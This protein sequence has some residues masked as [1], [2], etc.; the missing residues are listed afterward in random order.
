MA[1]LWVAIS[2]YVLGSLSKLTIFWGCIKIFDNVLGTVT[3]WVTEPIIELIV[4]LI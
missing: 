3:I 2:R 1:T 4:V